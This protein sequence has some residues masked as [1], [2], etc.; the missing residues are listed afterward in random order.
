MLA[1]FLRLFSINTPQ[2]CL[3]LLALC[4]LVGNIEAQN[5]DIRKLLV[6]KR[7]GLALFIQKN[8]NLYDTVFRVRDC[9]NEYLEIT[10][11]DKFLSTDL[12]KEGTW[13]LEGNL[14]S[15]TKASGFRY[16][17]LKIEYI[18]EDSLA[19]FDYGKDEKQDVFIE[20]Y[21]ICGLEDKTFE[22]TREIKE[23]RK[24]WGFIAGVQQFDNT[25]VQLGVANT[26]FEWNNVFYAAGLIAEVAPWYNRYG[27]SA[28]FWSED[29]AL[30]GAG[31]VSYTDFESIVV[32]FRPMVGLSAARLLQSEG[33]T[34]HLTYSYTVLFAEKKWEHINRH[35]IT[36]R[37]YVPF[38]KTSKRVRRII[39]DGAEY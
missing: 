18:S 36:F 33:L 1:F 32:G 5:K 12:K 23:I 24:S 27:L 20:T 7:W 31:L 6:G 14:I 17:T 34:A 2:K 3:L 16:K 8:G 30:Y 25:Y 35:A 22:D 4:L 11:D 21:K 9:Q 13:K 15:L 19:L 26:K 10:S 39:R 37:M 29:I 28:N 38:K